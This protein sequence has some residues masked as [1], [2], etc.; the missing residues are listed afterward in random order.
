VDDS[1]TL[2]AVEVPVPRRHAAPAVHVTCDGVG[3]PPFAV[4]ARVTHVFCADTTGEVW[5]ALRA[6]GLAAGDLV[7]LRVGHGEAE[8]WTELRVAA[9]G[10]GD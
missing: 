3:S 1:R 10:N 7:L 6:G 5:S 9:P 2:D 8:E 4:L